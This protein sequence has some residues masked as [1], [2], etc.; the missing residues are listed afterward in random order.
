MKMI[1][2]LCLMVAFAVVLFGCSGGLIAKD[3]PDTQ[4]PPETKSPQPK[5]FIRG[6][7]HYNKDEEDTPLAGLRWLARHQN[8]DGSWG[9]K[10]F[11]N[12]CKDA[13]CSGTGDEQLNIGLT[14]LAMCAFTEAGYTTSS[15]DIYDDICFGDVLRKAAIYLVAIQISDGSFGGVKAGKFIYNQAIATLALTDLYILTRDRPSGILFKEPVERAVK[16]LL[17]AQNPNSGWRYQPRDGQSDTSV[18][19]WVAMALKTAEHAGIPIPPEAFAG[20][21]SFLDDVT[22][23]N[24][25]KVGYNVVGSVYIRNTVVQ[26]N[27]TAIGLMTR[28]FID[29]NYD[30]PLIRLGLGHLNASIPVWDTSKPGI[31]DFDYWFFGS[32]CLNQYDGPSGPDWKLWSEKIEDVLINNQRL[33]V[34]G[35]CNGSWDPIDRWSSE[36]G[37]IYSTAINTINIGCHYH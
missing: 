16:F 24:T 15:R 3:K 12:Q 22:D 6:Q 35:C 7:E 26:P 30:G 25:G 21:K 29:K 2:T 8:P 10:S 31:I 36:G 19:G 27:L 34:D 18:T 20:I 11:Q 1:L 23:P 4:K 37:R 14:G 5:T 13:K 9:A 32:Y 28:K 17:A 33:K